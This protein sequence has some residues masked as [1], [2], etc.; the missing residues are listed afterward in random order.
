M[1]QHGGTGTAERCSVTYRCTPIKLCHGF[2]P[3]GGIADRSG[4]GEP[5]ARNDSAAGDRGGTV[6]DASQAV[7]FCLAPGCAATLSF[8]GSAAALPP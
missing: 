3:A 8:F 4:R 6:S 1:G 7:Y 2:D 5:K